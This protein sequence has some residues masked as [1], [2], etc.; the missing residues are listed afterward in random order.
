MNNTRKLCSEKRKWEHKLCWFLTTNEKQLGK[1]YK[2]EGS[3][4]IWHNAR[5]EKASRHESLSK[6]KRV[7]CI[8]FVFGLF[9]AMPGEKKLSDG[10]QFKILTLNEAGMSLSNIARKIGK[11]KA[12]VM[13]FFSEIPKITV[14]RCMQEDR[15]P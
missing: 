11:S 7:T 13:F 14:V 2:A 10:E 5:H 3:S 8:H 9:N 12:A 6:Y 4:L 1:N 15:N